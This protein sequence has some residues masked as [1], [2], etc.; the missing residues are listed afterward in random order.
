M[1]GLQDAVI[2]SSGAG[3]SARPRKRR[4]LEGISRAALHKCGRS[5]VIRRTFC[6]RLGLV[7][8]SIDL[9]PFLHEPQ[10]ISLRLRS[11]PVFAGCPTDSASSCAN[12]VAEI[13]VSATLPTLA[14]R[15]R[16]RSS[17]SGPGSRH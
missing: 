10:Q 11:F 7:D 5:R 14:L 6:K 4:P 9:T 17:R 13:L 1:R 16:F 8:C 2:A 3:V 15:D 12:C